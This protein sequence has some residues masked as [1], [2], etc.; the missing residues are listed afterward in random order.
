MGRED[1]QPLWRARITSIGHAQARYLWLLLIFGIFYW[2]LRT[3][4]ET[5][6]VML[7]LVGVDFDVEALRASGP[8]VLFFIIIVTF[9]TLRAHGEALRELGVPR[10]P[11]VALSESDQL[12]AEA[13]DSSP[14]PLDFAAYSRRKWKGLPWALLLLN[15]P[16][17]FAFFAAEGVFLWIRMVSAQ[18]LTPDLIA[19]LIVGAILGIISLAQIVWLIWA[20]VQRIGAIHARSK[21]KVVGPAT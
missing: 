17:Y 8:A 1:M 7:P 11:K 16:L 4:V 3:P 6:R 18:T 12:F 10:D 19:L 2:S 13:S 9:G 5:P 20:R 14:N 15:Y 21:R